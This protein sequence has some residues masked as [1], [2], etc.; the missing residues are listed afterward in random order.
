MSGPWEKYAAG[1]PWT[2]YQ[3]QPSPQ[4]AAA[5]RETPVTGTEEPS[6]ANTGGGGL[7]T[8][9]GEM[10]RQAAAQA[11]GGLSGLVGSV[12]P[13]PAG[14]G[15]SVAERV[16]KALTPPPA[17]NQ[18]MGEEIVGLPGAAINK[19]ADIVGERGAKVSPLLGTIGKTSVEAL[20]VLLGARAGVT[21]RAALTKEQSRAA[22]ARDAGF[23]LTPE[24]MGSG[25]VA[26]TAASLAGEPRLARLMS[27]KNQPVFVERVKAQLGIPK[28]KELNLDSLKAVRKSAAKDYEDI[29]GVGEIPTDAT[30]AAEAD[31]IGQEYRSAAGSFPKLAKKDIEEL[32]NG[33]KVPRFN[34][35][36]AIDQIKILRDQADEFFRKGETRVAKAN[37][38]AA[39]MI[40]AQIGRYLEQTGQKDLLAKYQQARQKIAQSYSV[41][42]VLLGDDAINPQGLAK[43]LQ[44]G[45]PLSGALKQTGQFASDFERSSQKPSH[46]A[47]GATLHDMGLAILSLLRSGGASLLRE[48]PFLFARPGMRSFMASRA[49]QALIDP[50]TN[51][52]VPEALG[53]STVS[54]NAQEKRP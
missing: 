10:P 8:A 23:R 51:L 39:D 42:R 47:T 54:S 14:Q 20:P 5:P 36:E 53:A 40:E 46:M 52:R 33:L 22:A 2:K 13:G 3:A 27:K 31:A 32:T 4:P 17:G 6:L 18:R 50:R 9:I 44:S 15:A 43:Q 19:A 25:K 24:E 1:G 16:T 12:L 21:P 7:F 28:N 34:S 41:Q 49:G 11:I 35:S 26:K 45:K 37:R 29:R 48:A 38:A 30:Y